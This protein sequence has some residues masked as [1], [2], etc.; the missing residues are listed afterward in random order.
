MEEY[1]P[2]FPIF[3]SQ[4]AS[5]FVKIL[6]RLTEEKGKSLWI[7]K[8]PGHLHQ[9]PLIQQMVEGAKFIHI[10]RN[11]SDVVA[12][13]YEVTQNHPKI[14]GDGWT[15]EQCIRQW[16]EDIE[17]SQ[18]YFS[19]ANHTLVGY[20]QLVENPHVVLMNICEFLEVSFDEVMLQEYGTASKG[21]IRKDES[22]KTS[23][24]MPI[25]SANQKKFYQ[26]FDEVEREHILK[27]I[28][29]VDLPAIFQ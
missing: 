27:E 5:A 26:M 3:I 22:W 21:L 28:S 14:W 18:I 12:S 11:G 20:E 13:L 8:T 16:K 29:T 15:I 4:Y 24:G 19:K 6:D 9:I 10:I 25:R 1:L 7:E 17:I 23:V 2:T